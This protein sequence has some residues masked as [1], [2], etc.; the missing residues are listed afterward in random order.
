M[1]YSEL[2]PS[3]R[4]VLFAHLGQS[5]HNGQRFPGIFDEVA[6]I[7]PVCYQASLKAL[8]DSIRAVPDKPLLEHIRESDLFLPWE[9][10]FIQFGLATLKIT[11]V[12]ARLC[13]YY[14]LL[15][16][17]SAKLYWIVAASWILL[18]VTIG[19]FAFGHNGILD[20][21]GARWIAGIIVVV[22][23]LYIGGKIAPW[24]VKNWIEPDSWF[25]LVA[26]RIK[27]FRSL[28]VAR[29]L[30]QYLLNLGLCVQ[31]GMDLPRSLGVC[32]KSEPV[33]W[34]RSRY[35]TV[36]DLVKGGKNLSR[37]FLE[38]GV[39]SETRITANAQTMKSSKLWEP[40]ITEVV[41]ASFNDQLR[42]ASRVLPLLLLVPLFVVWLAVLL[43][44]EVL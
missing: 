38:T 40:G 20:D 44:T 3:N 24:I 29:S 2:L 16:R 22:W 37:A 12:F 6:Q 21:I 15:G 10:R 27:P 18:L 39:L 4:A 1:S 19:L 34:L 30:Y 14:V 8:A 43:Q 5:L 9:V 28:V 13:D 7:S 41:R 36:V 31:S 11:E 26:C 32:A 33:D 23:G 17:A 25:W 42:Y 35:Q